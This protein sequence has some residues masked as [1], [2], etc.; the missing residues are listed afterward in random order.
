[1]PARDSGSSTVSAPRRF[2]FSISVSSGSRT[3]SILSTLA[4]WCC[5]GCC[6]C[7]SI[8]A[9][10][11]SSS[12]P[13]PCCRFPCEPRRPLS[14]ACS[15][16]EVLARSM[17]LRLHMTSYGWI[18]FDSTLFPM[19]IGAGNIFFAERN[20]MN[21]RLRKANEEIEH[22]AKV[23]ERERIARDL[24]D[25]LGHTLSVIT[26]KSELAGQ[27]DRSRSPARRERNPRSRRDFAPGIVRSARRDS[28]IPFA[29]TRRRTRASQGHARNRRPHRAMRRRNHRETSGDCRR[30][31]CR[32]R[33]AKV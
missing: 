10:A 14:S 24:H 17:L 9:P 29:G 22:L 13:P 26:L 15:R 4:E 32:S 6:S 20:R 23:A 3:R 31:S 1:M 2:S 25:V 30:A 16:S 27:A 12:S 7:P 21:R 5:W 18:L 8:P 33:C 11:H 28:R 19:F